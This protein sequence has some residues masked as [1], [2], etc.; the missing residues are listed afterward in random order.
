MNYACGQGWEMYLG[1]CLE[2][3]P[4]VGAFDHV[5]CDPPYEVEAHTKARRSLKDATQKRGARNTGA[6]RRIDAPLEITFPAMTEEERDRAAVLFAAAR[7]WVIAFCQI[8]AVAAWRRSYAAAGLDWVRGG[9]W[10][11]PDG[12]PQFTGDRPGQGFECLAIG[13][14][15]GR[16]TWNGG[17]KHAVWTHALDHSHGGGGKREHPTMKPI[18]LMIELVEDFTD[19]GDRVLDAYAGSGTTGIACLRRGRRFVGVE[20]HPPYFN[21]ACERLRAEEAG[22]SLE[23]ARAGQIAM[24]GGSR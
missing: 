4:S 20:K 10:R 24:F 2:V 15:P 1:D 22:Q 14:R 17:G 8:E 11:K 12:A 13:H 19:R 3:V 16:K 9:I 18:A 21:L 23:A 5:I 7:R 6:V